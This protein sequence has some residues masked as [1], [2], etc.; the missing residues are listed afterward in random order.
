MRGQSL[1][2]ALELLGFMLLILRWATP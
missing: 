2:A 1:I